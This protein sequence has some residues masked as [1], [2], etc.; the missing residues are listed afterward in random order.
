[1][2]SCRSTGRR[3]ECRRQDN[4]L[5]QVSKS[6]A[7]TA[8]KRTAAEAPSQSCLHSNR[9][10]VVCFMSMHAH[11]TRAKPNDHSRCAR[12]ARRPGIP[13]TACA[14]ALRTPNSSAAI[15]ASGLDA[16]ECMQRLCVGGHH[17]TVSQKSGHQPQYQGLSPKLRMS[18]RTLVHCTSRHVVCGP[19]RPLVSPLC[20]DEVAAARRAGAS[21]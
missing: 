19:S 16:V 5:S 11:C 15:A 17:A 2:R 18:T 10:G 21:A 12:H 20:G 13:R 8:A 7:A 6:I 14:A 3:Q 4:R 1:M 9:G